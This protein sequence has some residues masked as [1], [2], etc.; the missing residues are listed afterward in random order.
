MSID[1]KDR[2]LKIL[3][4]TPDNHLARFGL[5]NAYFEEARFDLAAGEYR[6]CLEAQADWMAVHIALGH[7]LVKL[8]RKEEARQA[9]ET[10]RQL[11]TRQGH[12][13]PL[14]EIRQLLAQIA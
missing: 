13:Q 9:L 6:R 10:A 4:S 11:A 3:A 5:A 8:G 7:C 1:R 12:S 14:D 2:Y